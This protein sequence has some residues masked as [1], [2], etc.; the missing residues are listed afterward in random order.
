MMG[1]SLLDDEP[2]LNTFR[3]G[4]FRYKD[5][6]Y[7]ANLTEKAGN[8]ICHDVLTKKTVDRDICQS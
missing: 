1:N 2:N 7:E 4:S 3:D 6:Y 8:G 5:C